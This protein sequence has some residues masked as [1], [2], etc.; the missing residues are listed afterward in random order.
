MSLFA[1]LLFVGAG[2]R[3]LQAASEAASQS[4]VAPTTGAWLWSE[5][6]DDGLAEKCV[7]EATRTIYGKERHYLATAYTN[8]ERVDPETT[9]KTDDPKGVDAFK[10][11]WSEIIPTEKYDYRFS[12]MTYTLRDGLLAYKLT[13]STQEDC[14]ASHKECWLED[15]VLHWFDSVYFPGAGRREGSIEATRS[16]RFADAL[17]F[18]LR[19]LAQQNAPVF[20]REVGT[21][22]TLPSREAGVLTVLPSQK[23]THA[24]GWS[25]AQRRVRIF[26]AAGLD[27]P[28]GRV[29]AR[30]VELLDDAG[31]VVERFWFATDSTPPML[32]AMVRYEGPNGVTYALK[33]IERTAY[34]KH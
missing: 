31:A 25:R 3:E 1:A 5:A 33:S 14:G 15:G 29:E 28:V 10:H 17:P 30:E 6:W 13:A 11:H 24:V 2:C 4:D 16:V 12:T 27:L 23:D 8:K 26:E 32:N 21:A 18:T 22:G 7:Y 19:G 34:W 20:K 9:C